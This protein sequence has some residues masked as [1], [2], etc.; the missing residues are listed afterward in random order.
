MGGAVLRDCHT[1]GGAVQSV[2]C[3]VAGAVRR[4]CHTVGGAVRRVCCTV[5]GAILRDCHTVDRMVLRERQSLQN[6]AL[7]EGALL[8]EKSSIMEK[9]L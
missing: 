8:S 7:S 6:N 5:A 1:V 3:T 2:C 9:G 4:D